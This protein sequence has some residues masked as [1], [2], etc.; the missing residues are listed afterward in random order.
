M[1]KG[2]PNRA[3]VLC[4][5]ASANAG[6]DALVTQVYDSKVKD[7]STYLTLIHHKRKTTISAL[8]GSPSWYRE[9][10]EMHGAARTCEAERIVLAAVMLTFADAGMNFELPQLDRRSVAAMASPHAYVAKIPSLA[11]LCVP[12]SEQNDR[13]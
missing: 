1:L 8:I 5:A 4:L 2:N 9:H 13:T 6:G 11:P 7:G 10:A 3:R 12:I